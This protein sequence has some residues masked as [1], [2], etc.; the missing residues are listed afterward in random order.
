MIF[1]PLPVL[2]NYLFLPFFVTSKIVLLHV[3]YDT[4]INLEMLAVS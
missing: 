4:L 3:D 1:T 2:A